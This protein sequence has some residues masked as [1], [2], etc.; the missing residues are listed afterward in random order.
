MR[1]KPYLIILFLNFLGHINGQTV[2]LNGPYDLGVV[3]SNN[4]FI[5]I[6]VKNTSDSKIYIFRTESDRSVKTMI[7]NKSVLPDSTVVIRV[8]VNPQKEGYF[9]ETILVHFSCYNEPKKVKVSGY[10]QSVVSNEIACP[11]FNQTSINTS[12]NFLATIQ[13]IDAETREPIKDANVKLIKNGLLQEDLETNRSGFVKKEIELGLYYFIANAEGYYTNEFVQ[14]TNRRNNVVIIPLEKNKTEEPL[15]TT[16]EEEEEAIITDETTEPVIVEENTSIPQDTLIT[17]DVEEEKYP[18][19]P[20]SEYKP[21]NIVFLVDISNSMKYTG[22]LDLLKV[23]MIELT[24]ML[25]DIDKVT[26]VTYADNAN[27]ALQTTSGANKD[28]IIALIQSLEANGLTAGGK[29]MKMAYEEAEKAFISG[30]NNQVIMATDGGFNKGEDNPNKL[31]VK[32]K[33]KGIFISVLGIK[34]KPMEEITLKK[35]VGYGDGRF[36][37]IN[38]YEDAK[39]NLVDEIKKGAKR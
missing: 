32:Y 28:T 24:K 13:V 8:A 29:G 10:A 15:I 9:T 33:K 11:S 4:Y 27:I 39:T 35:V 37:K 14:Y 17:E 16:N 18:E 36:V 21:S 3:S 20:L 12:L 22:K 31:A 7:S 34:N 26:I 5:D 25:R 38:N 1:F 23:A 19:F 2:F 30:G 6:P